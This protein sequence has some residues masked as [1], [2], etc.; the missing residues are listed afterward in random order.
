L[1]AAPHALATS[2]GEQQYGAGSR[3]RGCGHGGLR[4]GR[5]GCDIT[6]RIRTLNQVSPLSHKESVPFT[7]LNIAVLTVS[8]TRTLQ[9]DT[10]GQL[11]VE[12][13]TEA[14]HHL[15][16][17]VLLKDDP[18]QIRAVVAAWIAGPPV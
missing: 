18:Y 14:G 15:A 6:L 17:R 4:A 10:P 9:T 11:L 2:P 7:P 5:V 8:D 3:G 1:V 16:D 13:L 12:R